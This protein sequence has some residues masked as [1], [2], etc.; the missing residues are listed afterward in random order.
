MQQRW[1]RVSSFFRSIKSKNSSLSAAALCNESF[2]CLLTG[3]DRHGRRGDARG[4]TRTNTGLRC[5][6]HWALFDYGT[7]TVTTLFRTSVGITW[8]G[9]WVLTRLLTPN[10]TH[11]KY[12]NDVI[13]TRSEFLR[14]SHTAALIAWLRLA[15]SLS[16]LI[17]D[18]FIK[19]SELESRHPG[20]KIPFQWFVLEKDHR[21]ATNLLLP[22]G[23]HNTEY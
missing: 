20:T 2:L 6:S 14:V 5:N 23:Q 7:G 13:L 3:W 21:M 9:S 18:V 8:H 11:C 10:H 12:N 15:H 16:T 17:V 4:S 19:C 1:Q 22:R